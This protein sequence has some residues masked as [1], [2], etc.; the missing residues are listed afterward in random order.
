M[1]KLRALAPTGLL[2]LAIALSARAH[3][4][5]Q[6]RTDRLIVKYR[7]THTTQTESMHTRSGA[8]M[9]P[10]RTTG[11]GAVVYKLPQ[12]MTLSDARALADEL[13]NG[14]DVEYAEP[15]LIVHSQ[16]LPNDSYY[17]SQWHYFEARGGINLPAAWAITH[18]SS[19]IVVAVLD[20]GIVAHEDLDR[21]LP[22]YDF[23]S[24]DR[25]GNARANDG[26]GR[27][28]DATDPGDWISADD[29]RGEAFSGCYIKSSSWHGTHVAGTIAAASNNGKGVAGINWAS[30][31]LP[32][33]VLGKCGG[34]TSDI[35]D[36][37]YWAAG[38]A[39][40]GMPVNPHPA[41]VLNLSLGGSASTCPAIYQD[42][43]DA[44]RGAGV[45]VVVSAGNSN[46]NS[47]GTAPANCAGVISVAAVDRAG[48]KAWY[49]N[50][51]GVT[52]AAPGGQQYYYN[53]PDAIWSTLNDG[54]THARNDVYRGYQGT[55][56]AAPHVAGVVSLM[57]SV[58]PA[59]SVDQVRE[60]LQN[61]ARAFPSDSACLNKC[62]AGIVDAGAA[63]AAARSTA[64][65][66]GGVIGTGDA[67]TAPNNGD[68]A[69]A[70]GG[71]GCAAQAGREFDPLL[72]A[73][74]VISAAT[75]SRKRRRA[76]AKSA[77]FLER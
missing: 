51:G 49:S 25:F 6:A 67:P 75:L 10:V 63:V 30:K 14:S 1:C 42:A 61:S 9:V 16:S 21:V 3:G 69:Y 26:N 60:I 70:D 65:N 58:N 73:M 20:T 35:V 53:D 24:G 17:G 50:F 7:N 2:C 29:A 38:F 23:V 72:L 11:S 19:D 12:A 52:L 28:A 54:G 47:A 8:S 34:Y 64:G 55:S 4:D 15:D 57:L 22:G 31:I 41:R 5:D 71:G 66:G 46:R 40:D 45:A 44:L 33:R 56:M 43:V 62:G 18:G 39:L 32:V 77:D 36:A 59:L 37:M 74:L 76:A 48:G 13:R 27:D 68:L